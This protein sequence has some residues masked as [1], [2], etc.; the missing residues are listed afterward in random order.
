MQGRAYIE[1]R[2][3]VFCLLSLTS[4]APMGARVPMSDPPGSSAAP[5]CTWDAESSESAPRVASPY[6]RMRGVDRREAVG[7]IEAGLRSASQGEIAV[8]AEQPFCKARA[9]ETF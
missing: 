5:R 9:N 1:F 2:L 4:L 7:P 8:L 3:Q 6:F